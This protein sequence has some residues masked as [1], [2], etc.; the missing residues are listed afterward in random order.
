VPALNW[1]PVFRDG[2]LT[3]ALRD[4]WLGIGWGRL[5]AQVPQ[6][7]PL[8]ETNWKPRMCPGLSFHQ[9]RP[10]NRDPATM[11]PM[12]WGAGYLGHCPHERADRRYVITGT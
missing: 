7:S 1:A 3:R 4:L 9:E 6:T 11:P 10:P 5:G 12:G 8:L 2:T